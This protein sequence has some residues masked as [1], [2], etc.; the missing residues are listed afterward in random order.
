MIDLMVWFLRG[1]S[2]F[3]YTIRGKIISVYALKDI[4]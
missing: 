4:S 2:P 1:T 3:P